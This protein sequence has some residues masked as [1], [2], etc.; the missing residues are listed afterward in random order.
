MTLN[1][2]TICSRLALL[3]RQGI[4]RRAGTIENW[5]GRW[6]PRSHS[7][8]VN[9]GKQDMG[10]NYRPNQDQPEGSTYV[11]RGTLQPKA[12]TSSG[13]HFLPGCDHQWRLTGP[14]P[15]EMV[16]Y[17]QDLPDQFD[18]AALCA[19]AND[20]DALAQQCGGVYP[21][22]R[23]SQEPEMRDQPPQLTFAHENRTPLYNTL[24]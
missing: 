15:S 19:L 18:V 17:S 8:E 5:W 10:W 1:P 13:V 7:T 21:T 14:I 9:V 2:R 12:A 11:G 22:L 6:N 20:G 16:S 3:P 4:Y 24:M 23:N